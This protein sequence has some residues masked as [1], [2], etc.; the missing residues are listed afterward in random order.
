MVLGAEQ[1]KVFHAGVAGGVELANRHRMRAIFLFVA[2]L[3]ILT[4]LVRPTPDTPSSARVE[5]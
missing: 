5:P 2:A 4:A 3:T 1:A